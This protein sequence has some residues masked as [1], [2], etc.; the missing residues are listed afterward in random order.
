MLSFW[1]TAERAHVKPDLHILLLWAAC[2]SSHKLLTLTHPGCRA[3]CSLCL[4]CL[5][6]QASPETQVG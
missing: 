2:S 3:F 4:E 1:I 5:S 6:L